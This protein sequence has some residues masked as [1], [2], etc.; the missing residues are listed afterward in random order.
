MDIDL[1]DEQK[2][3]GDT[4]NGLLE[5]RYDANVRLELLRS[6]DG[7][8]R[9]M[10]RQYAELGLLGLT[11]DE[12]YGGAGMGVDELSVVME[13][14]GRALVLEPF[15]A[16]VVLGGGLVAATGSPEQKAAILPGV[17]AGETLLAFACTEPGSRWSLT[18]IEAA[19]RPDGDG[20]IVSGEKI[21]VIGGD[22]ADQLVVT[23]KTAD[24]AL[25]LFLV[26]ATASGVHRD[27]YAMQDGLRG[28]DVVFDDAPAAAL[29]EPGDALGAIEGVL[30]VATAALCAEA[31]GAMERM[32]WFTVDYLKTRVQFGQPIAVF[33]TLQHRA[34]NMYVSLEQARSMA[35]LARLALGADDIDERR[36]GVRAAKVQIDLS[37]RHIGQEAVQLHGGIAMTMEYP[38]GHYLKRTTVIAK[39][40]ADTDLLLAQV[41]T[42]EGLVPAG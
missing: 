17:A 38:V 40:F 1:T 20:W 12:Q 4:V 5:K 41:G 23:A 10:W 35:L 21:A 7:W 29:G 13:S 18:E 11:F 15:L 14:F 16:T 39:T 24:G 25:G 26:D 8:S 36:R 42:G 19:A 37:A 3:L 31:V 33:Q 28:A 22:S 32:L 27:A 34:A 9:D 6:E 30:D 2:L